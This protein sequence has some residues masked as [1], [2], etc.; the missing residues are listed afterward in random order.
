MGGGG[1]LPGANLGAHTTSNAE[2][3]CRNGRNAQVSIGAIWIAIE[4]IVYCFT[5]RLQAQHYESWS[6][7]VHCTGSCS[8]QIPCSG[9]AAKDDFTLSQL[10]RPVLSTSTRFHQV[11]SDRPDIPTL[12]RGAGTAWQKRLAAR[13]DGVQSRRWHLF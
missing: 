5:K 7:M 1:L 4:V 11:L 13:K 10:P 3:L 6:E 9:L 12:A 8:P 2:A